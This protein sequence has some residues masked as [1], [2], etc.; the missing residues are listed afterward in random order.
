MGPTSSL[1]HFRPGIGFDTICHIPGPFHHR[2]TILF[3]LSLPFPHGFVFGNSRAT[4][5]WVTHPRSVLALFSLNFGVPMELEASELPKGLV[6]GRDENIHIRITPL[7]DVGSYN[8]PPL[9]G[10]TSSS[11]HF[12]PRISSNTKLSHPSLGSTTCWARSTTIAQ[13]CLLWSRLTSEFLRNSKLV[14]SQKASC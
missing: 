11:A 8:P 1:A 12:R 10:P 13:Y 4:S 2:S 3:V 6:L 14:S 9:K 5:Q 7:G